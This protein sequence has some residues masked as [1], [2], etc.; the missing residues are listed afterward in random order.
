[1]RLLPLLLVAACLPKADILPA[2][3]EPT[4]VQSKR[5]ED[6]RALLERAASAHGLDR[7]RETAHIEMRLDDRW[8]G[9]A[10]LA[11]PWPSSDVQATV[12]Q[13]PET[14]D[15]TV[16]FLSG[17]REGWTWGIEDWKTYT[18]SPAGDRNDRQRNNIRFILPTVQYFVDLPFRIIEA[19]IVRLADPQT[20]DG[21]EYDV[22]Y[23]TW[24]SVEANREFDQYLVF[25][26]RE[27]HRIDKVSYTVRELGSFL[28][29][30]CHLDDTREIDGIWIPHTLTVTGKLDADPK[31]KP[32][33]VMK[34][35]EVR[36]Q[37]DEVAHSP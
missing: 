37:S 12:T 3:I 15:S 26:D 14:F 31:K 36:V 13:T 25:I 20:I 22:V 33:H 1:M 6:G 35:T 34:L 18:E 23:A 9:I 27:T 10:R 8:Y 21:V 30:T 32:V 4:S 5:A 24:G 29:G 2:G 7:W 16:T 17:P 11:N 19:P 28:K